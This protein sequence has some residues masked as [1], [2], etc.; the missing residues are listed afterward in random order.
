M[1]NQKVVLEI[2][3]PEADQFFGVKKSVNIP[4]RHYAITH[5]QCRE[6]LKRKNPS[7]WADTY[8]VDPFKVCIDVLTQSTVN[9]QINQTQVESVPTN[10]RCGPEL[11]QKEPR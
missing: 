2:D 8:Y 9:S 7:I 6:A 4:H 5:I 11:L 10:S 3:E 1:V